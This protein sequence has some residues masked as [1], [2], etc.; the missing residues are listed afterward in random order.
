[1][2]VKEL[3]AALIAMI[4]ED[5]LE[6][7]KFTEKSELVSLLEAEQEAA[8]NREKGITEVPPG[9]YILGDPCYAVTELEDLGMVTV[10]ENNL[11][12]SSNIIH[13][14]FS[15]RFHK[16]YYDSET[17]EDADEEEQEHATKGN[18]RQGGG[19]FNAATPVT[20]MAYNLYSTLYN[21]HSTLYTLHSTLYTLHSTF[22]TLHSTL[23]TL[24]ST[25][26]TL[27]STLY[28]MHSTLYTLH[29]TLYTG[30]T[31][32]TIHYTIY[33]IHYTYVIQV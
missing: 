17:D 18:E 1:M 32:C 6:A 27:H 30:S 31:L 9:K 4:G 11:Y 24:H 5:A 13:L 15:E 8:L 10:D 3:K 12:I 33:T 29:S 20:G 19:I 22:Y 26:Y 25:L 28:T 2:T 7:K 14:S 23:Y 16:T 21:L